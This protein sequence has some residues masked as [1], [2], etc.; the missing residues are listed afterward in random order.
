MWFGLLVLIF[1][2]SLFKIC[3]WMVWVK[4]FNVEGVLILKLLL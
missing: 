1:D 2:S 4:L 3:D